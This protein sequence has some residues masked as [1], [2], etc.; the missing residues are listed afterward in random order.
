MLID[1]VGNGQTNHPRDILWTK[2]ALWHLGRYR[3]HGEL[4]HYIDRM[5]HEAIQAY[6]RDRGLRRDGWIG[7]NGET[8]WTLRVE[9]H[10][11][12]SEIRR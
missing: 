8:E 6:Q 12:R 4:N 5:L 11:C 2:A 3:H 10:H 9:L 1:V 7:P